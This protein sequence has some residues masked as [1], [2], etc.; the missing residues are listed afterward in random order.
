[1]TKLYGDAARAEMR[2]YSNARLEKW[3]YSNI[4]NNTT[5]L[6]SKDEAD[7]S[8]WTDALYTHLGYPLR[9]MSYQQAE[10]GDEIYTWRGQRGGA[11]AA[12]NKVLPRLVGGELVCMGIDR[13]RP[14]QITHTE[15]HYADAMSY[16]HGGPGP[17]PTFHNIGRWDLLAA[18]DIFTIRRI[19]EEA[20]PKE[21]D[22]T[23]DQAKT[24]NRLAATSD[25]L[26]Y[27]VNDIILPTLTRLDN[28]RGAEAARDAAQTA[29]IA[30]LA[31]AQGLDAAQVRA[32]I[33]KAVS[34]ALADLSITLETK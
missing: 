15:A 20:P 33:D 27:A 10:Q 4:W 26:A 14:G 17:G 18:A 24:L 34:E 22:M 8:D 11:N 7:C 1:M 21:E 30:T 32:S 31:K 5:N 3:R 28:A 13:R 19:I 6:D 16:G 29:A 2:R 25:K 23:P 9:G 12:F